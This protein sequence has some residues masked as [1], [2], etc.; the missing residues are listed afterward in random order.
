[1]RKVAIIGAGQQGRSIAEALALQ[2]E[3]GVSITDKDSAVLNKFSGLVNHENIKVFETSAQTVRDADIIIL[4]TPIDKFSSVL[5]EIAGHVKPGAIVTDVGSGKQKSIYEISQNLPDGAVYIPSHPIAGKAGVGPETGSADMYRNQSVVVIPQG[6]AKAE[7]QVVVQKMWGDMDARITP[8]SALAHDKLYGTISHF[9]HVIAFSQT[10]AGE[11][12]KNS[13]SA[14][15]DYQKAYNTLLDTTRIANASAPMWQA[16]FKDNK[17]SIQEASNGFKAR[18]EELKAA[19]E[20]ETS[21]KLLGLIGQA[22]NFRQGIPEDRPR[23]AIWSE[24][25]DFS[26][27]KKQTVMFRGKVCSTRLMRPARYR[28]QNGLQPPH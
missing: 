3:Y 17:A 16:I 6:P 21:D 14:E 19:L 12:E 20:S 5:H 25:Q 28:W 2:G 23:E 10:L 22:H 11:D 8:M 1:M 15:E 27:E 4:A 13:G 18:L 26:A 7:E 24:F 9:Q